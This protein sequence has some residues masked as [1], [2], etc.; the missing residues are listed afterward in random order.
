MRVWSTTTEVLQLTRELGNEHD[1]LAVCLV[2]GDIIVDHVPESCHEKNWHFLRHYGNASCKITGK[3]RFGNS[4][5]V[6]CI[7]HFAGRQC[8][9]KRLGGLLE[10]TRKESHT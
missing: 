5:E 9:I 7:N 6:P 8:L 2:K 1:C 10:G 3:R 4:L